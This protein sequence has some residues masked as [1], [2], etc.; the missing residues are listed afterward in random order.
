MALL[1]DKSELQCRA[2]LVAALCLHDAVFFRHDTGC[3]QG[4]E[5][6][7][8][9]KAGRIILL[10]EM[11][12]GRTFY[13]RSGSAPEALRSARRWKGVPAPL[14]MRRADSRGRPAAQHVQ[15]VVAFQR[16]KVAA[17]KRLVHRR[18]QGAKVGGDGH[19]LIVR[20]MNAV[21]LRRVHR[22]WWGKT[23]PRS[24]RCPLPCPPA[25][26][27]HSW[28]ARYRWHPENPA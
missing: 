11:R 9:G 21:S 27:A 6:G 15:V 10:R 14:S 26:S 8:Q 17:G 19:G 5:H 13:S 4:G 16:H 20:G 18:G 7:L 25:C 22:G 28:R 2:Y 3:T 23:A 12:T 1:F 24:S